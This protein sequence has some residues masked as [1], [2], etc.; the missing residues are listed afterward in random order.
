M[1]TLPSP[2]PVRTEAKSWDPAA[3][4]ARRTASCLRCGYRTS[5][6]SRMECRGQVAGELDTGN[7]WGVT[8]RRDA[9]RGRTAHGLL[10]AA[11]GPGR[12]AEPHR[13]LR[14]CPTARLPGRQGRH[15]L[16]CSVRAPRLL[17]H[18]RPPDSQLLSQREEAETRPPLRS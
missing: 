7:V 8:D 6:R 13:A 10:P 11:A 15:L 18:T 12:T 5:G 3:Q 1:S 4:G 2:G 9:G 14:G 17:K 16:L